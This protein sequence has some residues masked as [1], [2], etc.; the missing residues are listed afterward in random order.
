MKRYANYVTQ[1]KQ[2]N[3]IIRHSQVRRK[4]HRRLRRESRKARPQ[5][6][7]LPRTISHRNKILALLEMASAMGQRH[8]TSDA[9]R[10]TKGES[11][12]AIAL[13]HRAA[14]E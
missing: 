13:R 14:T 8:K 3:Y 12:K 4:L 7:I 2:R 10:R 11:E 5:F 6:E 1:R 9:K